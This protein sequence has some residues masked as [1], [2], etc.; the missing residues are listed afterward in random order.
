[1]CENCG[2]SHDTNELEDQD[3]LDSFLDRLIDESDLLSILA[4]LFG[5]PEPVASFMEERGLTPEYELTG[6]L[7]GKPWAVKVAQIP[8]S[9]ISEEFQDKGSQWWALDGY[10]DGELVRSTEGTPPEP[11]TAEEAA[12]IYAEYHFDYV[13]D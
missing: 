4:N 6:E 2:I 11:V 7:Y 12:K 9:E 5:E 1:M 3:A 13:A 10:Y 8:L